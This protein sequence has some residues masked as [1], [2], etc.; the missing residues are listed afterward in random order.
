M[1]PNVW[2]CDLY[3]NGNIYDLKFY[4]TFFIFNVK[5]V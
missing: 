1:I 3:V 2:N 4:G 5:P